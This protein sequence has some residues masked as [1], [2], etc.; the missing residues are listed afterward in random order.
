ME[1]YQNQKLVEAGEGP[2]SPDPQLTPTKLDLEVINQLNMHTLRKISFTFEITN[3]GVY[4]T[5]LRK[6][7]PYRINGKALKTT[8]EVLDFF[9]GWILRKLKENNELFK[10]QR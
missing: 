6:S 1:A 3:E 4:M 8:N 10:R 7:K 5:D 9:G 2:Q